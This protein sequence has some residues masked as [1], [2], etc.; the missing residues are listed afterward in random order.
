MSGSPAAVPLDFGHAL[1]YGS[2]SV[3]RARAP[4]PGPNA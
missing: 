2:G 3:T 4:L 1:G